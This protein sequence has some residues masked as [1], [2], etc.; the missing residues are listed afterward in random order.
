MTLNVGLRW[1]PFFGQNLTRGAIS[2]FDRDNFAENVKSTVFLN[3]PAGFIYPG[4]PGFPVGHDGPEQAV[5]ELLAARRR[6][7]GRARRRPHGGAFLVR[8]DVRLP[9][10]RV[11]TTSRRAPPFGNRS[12]ITDPPGCS[13]IRTGRRWR[14][15][16]DRHRPEIPSFPV[17]GPSA[18][19]IPTSTPRA[20][21][22]GTSPSS[23]RS[24]RTGAC[25]PAIWAATPTGCGGRSQLNPGVFMGLGPCTLQRRRI[26]VC[27][28]NGN[29]NQ[30]RVLSLRRE[31]RVRRRSSAI[32]TA[33]RRSAPRV[34]RPEAVG[35]ASLGERPE[36]Q[37]QLHA[38]ALLRARDADD[39]ADRHGFTNPANPDFD[40]GYCDQDRTH[41]GQLHGRLPD[42]AVGNAVLRAVA[43]NWRVSGIL[44]ARSGAG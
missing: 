3:A 29:L 26:P 34:S 6:R 17:G 9:D 38:V 28:T 19:W 15:A 1:E 39:C 22:R 23:S 5:D 10:R 7:V 27:T 42:A 37:R 40:R 21:S 2:I 41:I 4:D 12:L 14:S 8:V 16:S 31:S 24:A 13:T 20:S 30:R 44:N 32:S 43:S 36:P 25:R 35:A 18:R 33:T 11:L